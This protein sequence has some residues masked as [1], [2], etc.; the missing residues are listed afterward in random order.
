MYEFNVAW[1]YSDMSNDL[2][3]LVSKFQVSFCHADPHSL[4][5]LAAQNVWFLIMNKMFVAIWQQPAL[6]LNFFESVP[7]FNFMLLGDSNNGGQLALNRFCTI[8]LCHAQMIKPRFAHFLNYYFGCGVLTCDS[9]FNFDSFQSCSVHVHFRNDR[10]YASCSHA[11]HTL[12]QDEANR[13][14][15]TLQPGLLRR[16]PEFKVCCL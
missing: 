5:N 13:W 16:I 7:S 1:H 9:R 14:A 11:N 15:F 8:L 12:D 2:Q 4:A 3:P 6:Q 10:V